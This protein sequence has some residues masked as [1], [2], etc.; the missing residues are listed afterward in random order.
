MKQIDEAEHPMTKSVENWTITTPRGEVSA[1][2]APAA[3]PRDVVF[4]AAPGAGGHKQDRSMLALTAC[5]NARGVDVVAF[6]FLY[7]QRGSKRPDA[8]PVL[9]ETFEAVVAD[10][11]RRNIAKRLVIGGRSMGGRAASMLAARG[12][13]CD[14][15]LLVAYPLHPPKQPEKLR[16]AHLASVRVPTLCFNGTRDEFCEP[17]LM[18]EAMSKVGDNWTMHWVADADHSMH[19]LRRSG[20][21]DAEVLDEIG[22][23]T[24]E[25]LDRLG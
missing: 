11:R 17:A 15:L 2:F 22:A 14:G 9:E 23:A 13:E 24:S 21:S 18:N 3:Q 4:V 1:V 10:V 7:R 19:V 20:R 16:V 12:F 8:M 25:W 6:D 5:L